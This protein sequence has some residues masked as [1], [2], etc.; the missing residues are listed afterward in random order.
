M[1]DISGFLWPDG[2]AGALT[3]S[4][5]DGAPEDRRLVAILNEHSVRGTFNLNSARLARAGK[6]NDDIREDEVRS[7]Y[8]NHEVAT[9]GHAHPYYTKLSDE[10]IAE[11]ITADRREL[12]RVTGAPVTGHALPFGAY[13]ARV[14]AALR[15]CGICYS[16]TVNA[17]KGFGLPDDFIEWHPTCHHKADLGG[18]WDRFLE[19]AQPD[20]LFYL[21]GHSY[22][23]PRDSN[24][25]I[26]DDF[27]ASAGAEGSVW[28]ATNMEAFEYVAAWRGLVRSVDGRAFR[29]PSATDV[30]V[31]LEGEPRRVPAGECL[32]T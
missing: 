4:W 11:D 22:E 5:D 3:T 28:R 19:S 8:A 27:A 2:L 30:W 24:W 13:D 26:I 23:F 12:E 32:S 9:H 21:W 1:M 31:S 7:L 6:G 20:K 15:K 16:R 25:H 17:T 29:N 14:L 18:L 10:E